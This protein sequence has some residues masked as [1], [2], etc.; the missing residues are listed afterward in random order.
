MHREERDGQSSLEMVVLTTA[1][2][3]VFVGMR[4]YLQRAVEGRLNESRWS[5]LGGSTPYYP[6]TAVGT[7]RSYALNST[8][9]V[10]STLV[11]NRVIDLLNNPGVRWS[12]SFNVQ[13]HFSECDN[14]N[15]PCPPQ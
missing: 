4:W 11:Q 3:A 13:S 6:D 5:I 9:N 10:A 7:T 12:R 2:V 8:E 14:R 1:V 15:S